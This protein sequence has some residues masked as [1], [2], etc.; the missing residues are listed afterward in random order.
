MTRIAFFT[1]IHANLP[2]LEAVL[3]ATEDADLRL[4]GGD[5]VGMGPQ[6]DEV[7]ARL[8]ECHNLTCVLGNH[9]R[10]FLD[11]TPSWLYFNLRAHHAWVREQ[12]YATGR[13]F[14]AGWPMQYAITV[15]GVRIV[16]THYALEGEG[17]LPIKNEPTVDELDEMFAGCEADV[18]LYGHHHPFADDEGR[19]RYVNPGSAGCHD[20]PE[21]RYCVLDVADG[22]YTLTHHAAPYDDAPLAAAFKARPVPYKGSIVDTFFGGRFTV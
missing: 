9:D 15:G 7:V 19:A 1:D 17:W 2:A 14:M 12:V 21:A 13:M 5:A 10:W 4:F 20:R 18:V 16:T 11:G 22:A 6:P 3:T 8:A